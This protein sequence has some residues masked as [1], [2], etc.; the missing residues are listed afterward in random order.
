MKR[1]LWLLGLVGL[2]AAGAWAT[3]GGVRL[4]SK[5]PAPGRAETV[6]RGDIEIRVVETGTLEP[7]R[8]VEVKSKVSGRL[9]HLLVRE[10]TSVRVGQLLVEID[11]TEINSQVEQIRAQL[12]GARARLAQSEKAVL[13]QEDETTSRIREAEQSLA[14]AEARLAVAEAEREAQPALTSGEIA[15]A[16]ATMRTAQENLN[17]LV[18]SAHPQALVQAE[19]ALQEAATSERTSGLNYQRQRRL[20]GLG[21]ASRREQEAAETEYAGARAR[22][23]QARARRRVIEEQNRLELVNAQNRVSEARAALDRAHAGTAQVGI[24]RQQAVAARAAVEQSR[25][26]IGLAR[27]GRR[28]ARM[29]DDAAAEARAA[30]SQLDQQL[31]EVQVRQQDTRLAATMSGTVTRRYMEE[32]ELI[33]S[34]VGNFSSGT[35]VLQIADL[36]KMLVKISVN[37]VD[38]SR[39]RQ[40]LPVE[41]EL[42]GA[43]G[44]RFGG[45]VSRVAPAA[46]GS[47]TGSDGSSGGG[48]NA[49]ATGGVVRFAVEVLVEQPDARM[50]PG[51]SARCAII[52]DRRR[53]TLRLPLSCVDGRSDTAVVQV[54]RATR[55]EGKPGEEEQPREIR[56]GLRGE[57]HVEVLSGLREGERVRVPAFQGPKRQ[58]M[59]VEFGG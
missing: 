41:I 46:A 23:E 52:L 5:P 33:T 19:S 56:V 8:K 43:R 2:V 7:L 44:E 54:V 37:E 31:Q 3:R 6:T 20:Y 4:G 26:Q 21:F 59:D 48:N 55:R 11:P 38:V 9:A 25:A 16:E 27:T 39:I 35:P 29:R 1:L 50:K 51:M 28:Q 30:V 57:T 10:G 13:L 34:G 24:R 58:A 17:L 32:G 40:G 12:A 47:A 49:G 53:A 42:D 15:Q 14:S 36:S 22:L 18:A 45:V